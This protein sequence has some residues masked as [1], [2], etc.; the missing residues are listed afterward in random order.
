VALLGVLSDDEVAKQTGRSW[1]AVRQK[2][3]ALDIPNP[4]R[5][6]AGQYLGRIDNPELIVYRI[7]PTRVRCMREWALDYLAVPSESAEQAAGPPAGKPVAGAGR[8]LAG[9]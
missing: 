2:R 3:E 8:G 5:G 4:A 7:R 9:R 6:P 1:N